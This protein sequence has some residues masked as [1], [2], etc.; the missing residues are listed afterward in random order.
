MGENYK[1]KF[2]ILEVFEK[3]DYQNILMGTKKDNIDDV[4]VINVFKKGPLINDKFFNDL[5]DSL[6]NLLHIE[7]NNDEIIVVTEYK[8]GISF[9]SFLSTAK[10]DI[11]E[12]IHLIHQYLTNLTSYDV[13]DNYFTN[14][15]VDENQIISKN[16]EFRLNELLIL[17]KSIEDSNSFD[18]IAAKITSTLKKIAEDSSSEDKASEDYKK[19]TAFI[20]NLEEEDKTGGDIAS[21]LGDFEDAFKDKEFNS[22]KAAPNNA[23]VISA[24][25][26]GAALAGASMAADSLADD[27]STGAT[28]PDKDL[29]D[30]SSDE[31]NEGLEEA[32]N[33]PNL[34]DADEEKDLDA[35]EDN[36]M[37]E[38]ELDNILIIEEEPEEEEKEPIN[39]KPIIIAVLLAL[40]AALAIFALPKLFEKPEPP[41]ASFE[42]ITSEDKIKFV[43]TSVANGKDNEIV[44]A[45]WKVIKNEEEKY[46]S[47]KLD[48]ITLSFKS[49]GEYIVSLKVQDKNG[50]WSEEYFETIVSD[51]EENDISEPINDDTKEKLDS[52][53]LDTSSSSNV[54]YDNEIFRSGNKSIKLDLT[55]NDGVGE[56]TLKDLNLDRN[57]TLSM[58]ILSNNTDTINIEYTGFSG[59][60]VKFVKEVNYTPKLAN[61]WD[62]FELKMNSTGIDKIRLKF[63]SLNSTIWIDDIDTSSY[64]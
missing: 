2:N 64:K 45:L 56:F 60:T 17:D 23:T 63:K 44:A 3:N 20:D 8:E 42:R 47:D 57:T 35:S 6:T 53:N 36:V 15:F 25:G 39:K 13:F 7:E 32:S 21:I 14:I 43:N 37:K 19:L 11:E 28:G 54:T 50:L 12:R 29:S 38:T 59:D 16:G 18:N 61:S 26:A 22:V 24:L 30:V 46:S 4:V 1:S 62:L 55:Q 10:L 52:V 9:S 34:T 58:W 27:S 51:L 49:E 40:I 41:V 5:K 33:D 48:S 31:A